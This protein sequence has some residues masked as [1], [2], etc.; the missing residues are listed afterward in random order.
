MA[1]RNDGSRARIAKEFEGAALG[2]IRRTRR[3]VKMAE[4]LIEEPSASF[5]DAMMDE[6]GLEGAY[7]FLGNDEVSADA[8][9]APHIARSCERAC[10]LD[11]FLVVHDSSEFAFGGESPRTGLGRLKSAGS[12]GFYGHFALGVAP[13]EARQPLG[14]LGLTTIFRDQRAKGKRTLKERRSDPGNESKRWGELVEVVE[15]RLAGRGTPV[16]VMDR[17]GD[18]YELFAGLLEGRR[19]FVIRVAHDRLLASPLD[20]E[21]KERPKLSDALNA[22]S[23]VLTRDVRIARRGKARA[24]R[25]KKIHPA[26]QERTATLRFSATP[27]E[28][29]RPNGRSGLPSSLRLNVV[30][31]Q[32]SLA[33]AGEYEPVEWTLVTSEPIAAVEDIERVVDAYRSRWVIEEYFKALK[34][35]CS[36]EKRQLESKAS[37]LNALA[38]FAPIAWNLLLLRSLA[39][40]SPNSPATSV[41]STT[42][43]EV[44]RAV[45]KSQLSRVPT[46]REALL[47]VAGLGGHLKAN[48]DPGWQV[49]GRGY[50]KLLAYETGWLAAR[51]EM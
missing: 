16:H 31:V 37:L 26:R 42:Q 21:A 18:N 20:P 30:R 19:R 12:Q 13:G 17:E 51:G 39:R 34:T 32:E 44:L 4:A 45:G 27:V 1:D 22:A 6:A 7:R 8:I 43:L 41:L 25:A 46:V 5:P 9:L 29:L 35:G 47:A 28:L 11:W 10:S 48:G 14:V 2:D 33:T 15:Q 36:Y 49:L 38:V 40:A 24:P 3:L 50:E 23:Y